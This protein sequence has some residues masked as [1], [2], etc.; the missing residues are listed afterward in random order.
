MIPLCSKVIVD[1]VVDFFE[2]GLIGSRG[3]NWS[4]YLKCKR[5]NLNLQSELISGVE[6]LDWNQMLRS[7]NSYT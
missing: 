1:H 6:I 5:Q 4:V 3:I 7:H 2:V